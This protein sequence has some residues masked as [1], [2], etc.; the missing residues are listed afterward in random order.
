MPRPLLS[1]S[2]VPLPLTL[3]L[4]HVMPVV[5]QIQAP[6]CLSAALGVWNWVRISSSFL[7]DE[8]ISLIAR[9]QT[10][11]SL[12]QPP[13]QAAAYL[14]AEC[15]NGRTFLCLAHLVGTLID[16]FAE[17]TIEPVPQGQFYTGPSGSDNCRCNSVYYSL[18]SGCAGCQKGTW[19][20]YVHILLLS[21]SCSDPW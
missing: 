11:N 1:S 7:I 15:S 13:C 9:W 18:I 12:N 19:L 3:L 2:L 8:L 17:F 10:Y 6:T 5:A 4:V 16:A 20:P 14:A 21:V